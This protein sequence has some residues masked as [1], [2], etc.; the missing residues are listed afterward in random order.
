MSQFFKWT[1][2]ENETEL[3]YGA[4]V[5]GIAFRDTE[6]GWTWV[7]ALERLSIGT[8]VDMESAKNAIINEVCS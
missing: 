8:C 5:L 3:H 6:A 7:V 4:R 1:T 2:A